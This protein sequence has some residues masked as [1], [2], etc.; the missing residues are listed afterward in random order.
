[1]LKNKKGFT[2]MEM[3]V[4]VLI[5]GVLGAIAFPQY[6]ITIDRTRMTTNLSLLKP[7]ADAVV[8]YYSFNDAPP[9]KLTK[10]P[11]GIPKEWSVN[12]NLTA[13]SP[14]G[15]CTLS[16]DID[17]TIPTSTSMTCKRGSNDE[18]KIEYKYSAPDDNGTL[19]M[20]GPFI[21]VLATDTDRK[22]SLEKAIASSGLVCDEN[23]LC[24]QK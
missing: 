2:L 17:S 16:I 9:D 14:D 1:M 10:L 12:D 19:K 18:Y 23:N 7:I 6:S 5:I 24:K 22:K 21:E 11:V 15:N 3:L 4:V 8:Q 20:G 13:T